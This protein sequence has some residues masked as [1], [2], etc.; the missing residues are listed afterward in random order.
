MPKYEEKE[1]RR[2][3]QILFGIHPTYLTLVEK[4]EYCLSIEKVI[5]LSNKEGVSTDYILKGDNNNLDTE[6]KD[7]LK[8]CSEKQID[9]VFEIVKNVIEYVKKDVVV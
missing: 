2:I 3:L 8:E 1:R 9:E 6:G 4:G 7:I 5:E